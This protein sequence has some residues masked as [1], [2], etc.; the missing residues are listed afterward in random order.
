MDEILRPFFLSVGEAERERL[1]SDL[2]FTHAAPVIRFTL[3][4]RLGF[5]VNHD[6]ANPH[7]HD[8]EDLYH[9]AVAKLIELLNDPRLKSGQA[10]IRNFR[11]Y[12]ARLA[13]NACHDYLRAKSPARARLKNNLRDLLER[14]R[15]F[16][17]WK[18]GS[19]MLCGFAA[20]RN[21]D[22][23]AGASA[24][25]MAEI[26]EAPEAFRAARFP[27][28]D[29]RRIPLARVVAEIFDASRSPVELDTLV[30]VVA[31]VLE[32]KDHPEVSMDDERA[33]PSEGL[34]DE[35]LPSDSHLE[36]RETLGQLWAEI[37]RLPTPQR[38]TI[39]LGFEDDAGDDLFSLLIEAGLVTWPRL[40]RE[41]DRSLEQLIG[42]W[43][44]M[45]MDNAA[46]AEELGASR[47]QVSKWRFRALRRLE[48]ALTLVRTEK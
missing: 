45:P 39:C 35:R 27:G 15:D 11:Q 25:R 48:Q 43:Q 13:T 21:M 2:I 41:F 8:A 23:S 31:A 29:A 4:Q 22:S 34:A 36:E 30:N 46:I 18:T 12:A 32:I 20:W 5:Y 17:A 19:E 3:R 10:E 37:K 40:A 26:E 1:L 14:H 6:G 7:I 9:E 16:A 38:D 42:L 33:L 28:A 47:Q 24:N 44:Q